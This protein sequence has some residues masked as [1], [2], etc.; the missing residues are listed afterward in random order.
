MAEADPE[1]AP[2]G[3]TMREFDEYDSIYR[4]CGWSAW[5]AYDGPCQLKALKAEMRMSRDRLREVQAWSDPTEL[6]EFEVWEEK[7][8][9]SLKLQL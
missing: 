3:L 5:D 1:I 2:Q 9:E 8:G 7:T 4:I 6:P